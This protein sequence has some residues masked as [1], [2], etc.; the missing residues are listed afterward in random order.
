MSDYSDSIDDQ[1]EA[2]EKKLADRELIAK[3]KNRQLHDREAERQINW[4][5][6]GATDDLRD[7]C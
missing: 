4:E 1:I 6:N 3:E 2:I 5:R 7:Y